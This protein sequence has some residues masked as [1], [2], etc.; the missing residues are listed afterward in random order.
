MGSSC[1]DLARETSYGDLVPRSYQETSYRGLAKRA[2]IDL[3]QRSCQEP[4][5]EILYRDLVKR[6]AIFL[7]YLL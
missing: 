4:L 5:I 6:A 3:A 2:L 1:R 7:R